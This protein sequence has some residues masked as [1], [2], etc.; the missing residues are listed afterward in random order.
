MW[1]G[2]VG[3]VRVYLLTY[4]LFGER[5]DLIF[6]DGPTMEMQYYAAIVAESAASHPR[7]SYGIAAS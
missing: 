4:V 5:Y 1:S 3:C 2:F 6:L 7:P